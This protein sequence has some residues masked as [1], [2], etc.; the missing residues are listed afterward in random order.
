MIMTPT[1]A[2][3]VQLI[4]WLREQ[5]VQSTTSGAAVRTAL[6]AALKEL[7]KHSVLKQD[8]MQHLVQVMRAHTHVIQSA[9]S[10]VAI[11]NNHAHRLK[12]PYSACFDRMIA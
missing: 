1:D 4:G 12:T 10:N 5:S 6:N 7:A 9:V 2:T 3:R 11:R 8:V